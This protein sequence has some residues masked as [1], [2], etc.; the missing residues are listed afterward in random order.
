LCDV[1]KRGDIGVSFLSRNYSNR[2]WWNDPSSMCDIRRTLLKVHLT[3]R[4]Y[5]DALDKLVTKAF[6]LSLTDGNTPI[7]KEYVS[8]VFALCPDHVLSLKH[9]FE[10][11][12]EHS[13]WAQ[14][15]ESVQFPNNNDSG[16]MDVEVQ[17][18]F[19]EINRTEFQAI[20]DKAKKPED[21]L[22]MQATYMPKPPAAHASC[23]V[24]NN[25]HGLIPAADPTQ[26]DLADAID[27]EIQK[28]HKSNGERVD[29]GNPFAEREPQSSKIKVSTAKNPK[30]I[31]RQEPSTSKNVTELVH[32]LENKING[33]EEISMKSMKGKEK[34]KP[35]TP[36]SWMRKACGIQ[37]DAATDH[38]PHIRPHTSKYSDDKDGKIG[39]RR[40]PP[41]TLKTGKQRK[42]RGRKT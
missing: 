37:T 1:V 25:A 16:W 26:E 6:C 21:L 35:N 38:S 31:L 27:R 9:S 2:V 34:Q 7:V 42:R 13:W 11:T 20:L 30:G 36:P 10:R 18:A 22:T 15:D 29:L 3:G 41:R 28:T 24:F 5:T 17:A 32:E 14:Y 39:A 23:T 33:L 8:K 19:P 4:G 12:G 40:T